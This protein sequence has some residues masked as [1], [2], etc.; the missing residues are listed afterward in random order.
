M[1]NLIKWFLSSL[2]L[3]MSVSAYAQ[4]GGEGIGGGTGV[5][6]QRL[7]KGCTNAIVTDA[8]GV[9]S[10]GTGGGGGGNLGTS[11][12][13]VGTSLYPSIDQP[14]TGITGTVV[15]VGDFDFTVDDS[16]Q[17][18]VGM[19]INPN[20]LG[21]QPFA[22]GAQQAQ[23]QAINSN[24]ITSSQPALL[25]GTF[26]MSFG[27]DRWNPTSNLL[28]NIG[29]FKALYV[30][31]TATGNSTWLQ[32]EYG[33]GGDNDV[34]NAF[35]PP[36]QMRVDSQRGAYAAMF[37]A[38]SNASL[39]NISTIPIVSFVKLDRPSSVSLIPRSTWGIYVQSEGAADANWSGAQMIGQ[40]ISMMSAGP[41]STFATDP[42]FMSYGGA[43]KNLALDCGAGPLHG[44][45]FGGYIS[46]VTGPPQPF[47]QC[48][49]ALE[50]LQNGNTIA[51]GITFEYRA[52]TVNA[53]PF[54]DSV[55]SAHPPA[56]QM[57]S[58]ANGY[59]IYW[60]SARAT[61]TWSIDD[62]STGALHSR[63]HLND[64]QGV[65]SNIAI[66][67]A[68]NTL[69]FQLF[70]TDNGRMV[71]GSSAGPGAGDYVDFRGG[72]P[73]S[74][75][76]SYRFTSNTTGP[77]LTLGATTPGSGYTD[78]SYTGV[79]VVAHANGNNT[80]RASITVAGG[81][82]TVFTITDPGGD[83]TIGDTVSFNNHGIGSIGAITAGSGYA[84][85]GTY[86]AVPLT[87]GTG[88]GATA[89]IRIAS[90]VVNLVNMQDP[91][92]GY[93]VG[94][95]LSA[96][97]V[98]LGGSG[99]G[100]SIPVASISSAPLGTG[101]GFSVPIATVNTDTFVGASFTTKGAGTISFFPGTNTANTTFFQI[102]RADA[103]TLLLNADATNSILS[104]PQAFQVGSATALTL[105]QGA[106][107]MVKM[108]ASTTAPGAAGAKLELVCDAG[109]PG[110]AQLQ[111]S[112]GTSGT[113]TVIKDT[114]GAGVTGC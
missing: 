25:A 70:I 27:Y 36:I 18:A 45:P 55:I 61:P 85:P 100:F 6:G 65:S 84:T 74:N 72:T 30:G 11:P 49:S 1:N 58:G 99:S 52:L 79:A 62:T 19:T 104:A 8:R 75:K 22:Y 114:I 16:S 13:S 110:T 80:A 29:A 51:R 5:S 32:G 76:V 15:N 90:G 97:N 107:G 2:L 35:G 101:S 38:H 50:I 53:L 47:N 94:D 69:D 88:T 86:N 12:F 10:C 34:N 60:Y 59:G 54:V 37:S 109:H 98:N 4:D 33:A 102:Q 28:A 81:V 73:G 96:S 92:V 31:T 42:W 111:I 26:A 95:V 93:V 43:V 63:I 14:I 17:L 83:Y 66:N 57:P 23:I 9:A 71:T 3:L 46:Q 112:A 7:P 91:G 64:L 48:S 39:S 77:I 41:T 21:A 20:I 40:E 56:I 82:V 113:A 24:V 68:V 44:N 103:A 105:T 67:D 108:T 89:S 78:G 106:I 87:G